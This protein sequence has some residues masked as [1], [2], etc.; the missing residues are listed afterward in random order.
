MGR[1]LGSN[2]LISGAFEST[3]GTAPAPGTYIKLPLVSSNLGEERGL[4]SSDLL[5][6]GR[7]PQDPTYDVARNVGDL[8]VPVDV[9]ALGYWFKLLFGVPVTVAQ[10]AA[11]GTWT[12]TAQPAVNATIT[13]NGTV[14]TFVA[15]GATGPQINI[16]ANLAATLT[17]AAVVLNASVVA[18]VALA[19]YSASATVLTATLDAA[20]PTGNAYTLAAST[21]PVSSA[22]VSGAT[23]VGGTNKHTFS[24]GGLALPSLSLEIGHPDVPSFSTHYGLRANQMRIAM[25]RSGLLNAVIGCIAKGESTPVVATT[26]GTP[27][28]PGVITR[29][30]QATGSISRNGVT[31]GSV[32][33]AEVAFSNNLDPVETI[34]ADGRI[35]DVDAS[36]VMTSGSLTTRFSSNQLLQDAVNGV[37]VALSFG[38]AVLGIYSLTIN[39]PR[40]FLPRTKRPVSGPQGIQA[41]ANWEA[42]GALGA[43]FSVDLVNDIASYA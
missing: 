27:T 38:W 13:V 37:P 32:T 15:S 19:T 26:A 31:L 8:T 17:A 43:S 35:E 7:E 1:G 41:E 6:L 11:V 29:F 25:Q 4:I 42:S 33:N 5:G 30:A 24:S 3:Y 10:G 36:M 18:G 28:S 2:A 34:A 39:V 12:F 20:G 14:F 23:A 21:S 40:V 22:T 16:G 9:R